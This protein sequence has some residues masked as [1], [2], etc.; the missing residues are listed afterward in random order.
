MAKTKSDPS[1]DADTHLMSTALALAARGLGRVAPN[2]AVGCVLCVDGEVVGRG[3]TQAGGRPHAESE[4][5]RRAGARAK[6]ATAYVTLE[7]CA[8]QGQ[9]PPCADA[10][11][12]AGIVRAVI[13]VGDPDARVDG[14]GIERLKAAG[15][16]VSLGLCAEQARDLNAGFFKRI[17]KGLP[18]VCLKLATTADGQIATRAGNSQWITGPAARRR[19]HLLRATHNAILSGIGTVLADNPMLTCRLEGMEDRSPIRV[20]LDSTLRIP[21]EGK[22]MA[23]AREIPLWIIT[24]DGADPGREQACVNAGAEVIRVAADSGGRPDITA[25]LSALA[26]R[27]INRVL[28]EC[29]PGVAAALLKAGLVDRL[30]WF[31]AGKVIGADGRSAIAGFGVDSLAQTVRLT[32]VATCPLGEDMLETY[33]VEPY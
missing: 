10:L 21:L 33:V 9:T 13:A 19:G 15:I 6:G 12:E 11:I 22:L 1:A 3:W 32:R 14:S 8:H 7:P 31:R 4:A 23:S 25:A 20:I 5:L 16:E 28:G 26:A 29:G 27:G 17:E 30:Q 2:P 18:L 24:A